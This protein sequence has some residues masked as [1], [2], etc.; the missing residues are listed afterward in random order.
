MEVMRKGLI[1]ISGR[2]SG[3]IQEYRS[4]KI[5]LVLLGHKSSKTTEVYPAQFHPALLYGALIHCAKVY[6]HVSKEFI[7]DI[8][9]SLDNL[10]TGGV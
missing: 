10:E 2:E 5:I 6:T 7:E 4:V 9:S 8:V 3:K 1:K